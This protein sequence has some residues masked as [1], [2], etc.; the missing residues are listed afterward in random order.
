[1][2]KDPSIVPEEAPIIIFDIKY[3]VCMDKNGKDTNHTRHIAIRV[4]F[5]RNGENWNIHDIDWCEGGLKLADKEA[6]N[7]DEHDLNKIMKYDVVRLDNWYRTRVQEGWQ[8]T[9]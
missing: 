7:V 4:H 6:K 5:I 2:N 1:M 9:G 8:D 3:D